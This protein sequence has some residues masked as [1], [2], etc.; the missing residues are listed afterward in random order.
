[1]GSLC[2]EVFNI[3][4]KKIHLLNTEIEN[5]DMNRLAN[6]LDVFNTMKEVSVNN[7]I[8]A[9]ILGIYDKVV[10]KFGK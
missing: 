6:T 3:E 7:I 9:S 8:S 4:I 1:M 10:G 5:N 2:R